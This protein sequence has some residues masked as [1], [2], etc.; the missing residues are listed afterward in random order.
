MVAA[1][2]ALLQAALVV[3]PELVSAVEKLIADFKAAPP[4]GPMLPEV[5]AALDPLQAS[6]LAPKA[7]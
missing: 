2:L 4:A 3:A 5:K 6:L 7:A 1:I